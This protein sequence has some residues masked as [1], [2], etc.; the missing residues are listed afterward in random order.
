[1]RTRTRWT[2]TTNS[3]IMDQD[4]RTQKKEEEVEVDDSV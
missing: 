2:R 1:M 4:H 3:T